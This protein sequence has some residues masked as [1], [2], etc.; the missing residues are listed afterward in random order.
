MDN[1]SFY[2]QIKKSSYLTSWKGP[3][4]HEQKVFWSKYLYYEAF[5]TMNE[6][7]KLINITDGGHTGDNGGLNQ[8]FIRRCRVIIAGDASLDP[9]YQGEQ[10]FK[11]LN[12]VKTDEGIEVDIDIQNLKPQG[13]D[14]SKQIKGYSTNHFA[15]GKI[16]YPPKGKQPR[17]TGW[18]IYFKPAVC[19]ND[20][21][22]IKYYHE[23]HAGY[24]HP[25]TADQFYDEEQLEAQRMV[26]EESVKNAF[27][28]ILLLAIDKD[29]SAKDKSAEVHD[30]RLQIKE[31]LVRENEI[32]NTALETMD[33]IKALNPIDESKASKSI[34]KRGSE[35]SNGELLTKSPFKYL[36]RGIN[37]F[38]LYN[39]CPF[40]EENLNVLYS[41]STSIESSVEPEESE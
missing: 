1:P 22:W 8:L 27:L 20:P 23:T 17:S 15:V 11:V 18:L 41:Q 25:D 4:H 37:F 2:Q 35:L 6:R 9:D 10:L 24:P 19:K 39:N 13:G 14:E 5:A 30:T 26:G 28:D 7:K 31:E 16:K 21:G 38:F 33:E 12:Q 3:I 36:E 34:D 40:S 32:E 29:K